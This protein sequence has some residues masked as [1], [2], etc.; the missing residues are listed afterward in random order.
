MEIQFYFFL[1]KNQLIINKIISIHLSFIFLPC[2]SLK[3][4][5]V[6]LKLRFEPIDR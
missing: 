2:F 4:W 3:K 6:N 1:L 5:K